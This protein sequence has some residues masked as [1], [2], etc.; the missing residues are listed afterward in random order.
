MKMHLIYFLIFLWKRSLFSILIVLCFSTKSTA[1]NKNSST[2][3]ELSR[4]TWGVLIYPISSEFL[5]QKNESQSQ[6]FQTQNLFSLGVQY[7]KFSVFIEKAHFS[8]NDGNQTL[9]IKSETDM[10]SVIGRYAF[11]SWRNLNLYASLGLGSHS[12]KVTTRLL[13]EAF[14][15]SSGSAVFTNLAFG[16][17]VQY[18]FLTGE[19][20]MRTTQAKYLEPTLAYGFLFRLGLV[21]KF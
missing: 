17:Q 12:E 5:L 14:E 8:N 16:T 20:E 1:Q 9:H 10:L 2:E 21:F 3:K 7:Q 19:L 11:I 13:G 6:Y 4:K 18:E 15:D